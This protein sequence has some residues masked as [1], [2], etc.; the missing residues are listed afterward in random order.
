MHKISSQQ[1][2]EFF[3]SKTIATGFSKMDLHLDGGFRPGQTA[4][5]R[6]SHQV[7]QNLLFTQFLL[8]ASVAGHSSVLFSAKNPEQV[9]VQ[10]IRQNLGKPLSIVK[11]LVKTNDAALTPFNEIMDNIAIAEKQQFGKA[12]AVI[13]K[14]NKTRFK[15]N[16]I[17]II[18]IDNLSD[19]E[20]KQSQVFNQI[21]RKHN[22]V[23][24]ANHHA[25][26]NAPGTRPRSAFNQDWDCVFSVWM[27]EQQANLDDWSRAE[28]EGTFKIAM[29]KGALNCSPIDH[30]WFD[31]RNLL[32][33]NPIPISAP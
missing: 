1:T 17:S 29:E 19:Q 18:A 6:A 15:T 28:L 27:P 31:K 25:S 9:Q 20:L 5:F 10:C 24:L 30:L 13:K 26:R 8:Q 2:H 16:P 23:V 12:D 32:A 11:K 33:V 14:L 4:L 22:A 3:Q 7:D 21:A